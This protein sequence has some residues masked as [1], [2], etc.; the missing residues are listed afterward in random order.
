[1]KFIERAKKKLLDKIEEDLK[2]VE[3]KIYELNGDYSAKYEDVEDKRQKLEQAQN[4]KSKY[5]KRALNNKELKDLETIYNFITSVPKIEMILS[6]IKKMPPLNDYRNY[7]DTYSDKIIIQEE[8][9]KRRIFYEKLVALNELITSLDETETNLDSYDE[10]DRFKHY[11]EIINELKKQYN[12]F[13]TDREDD[14]LYDKNLISQI[15]LKIKYIQKKGLQEDKG[16]LYDPYLQPLEM[17]EEIAKYYSNIDYYLN[18]INSFENK[19]NY[20]MQLYEQ[21]PEYFDVK[22]LE[23]ILEENNRLQAILKSKQRHVANKKTEFQ[24]TRQKTKEVKK[25]LIA[26]EQRKKELTK[27]KARIEKAKSIKELGY[28][29]KKIAATKLSI[30][31]KDYIIIPIPSNVSNIVDLFNKET[32]LEVRIDDKCFRTFYLNDVAFGNLNSI[33]P[34]DNT[35]GAILIPVYELTKNHIDSIKNGKIGLSSSVLKIQ[36]IKIF[37]EKG[38][39]L[40]SLMPEAHVF[41]NKSIDEYV[42]DFL[43]EDYIEDSDEIKEYE[44]F[45]NIPNISDE[46]KMLKKAAVTKCLFENLKRPISYKDSIYVNGKKFFLNNQEVQTQLVNAEI[47][48]KK[49]LNITSKIKDYLSN[50]INNGFNIDILYRDLLMEYFHVNKKAKAEYLDEKDTTITIKEKNLSIKPMLPAKDE[51]IAKRYTRPNED[52]AYKIMKLANLV[53]RFAH[54]T[55][56]Q[57]LSDLLYDIKNDLIERVID[58]AK[59]NPQISLKKQFDENKMA[60]SVVMEIPGYNMIALHILNK[61]ESLSAKSHK[62]EENTKDVVQTSTILY[63]GVNRDLLFTMKK[64]NTNERIKLLLDLD[65]NTFYKL[66][67]RMGYNNKDINT[68]EEKVEFIKSIISD[69]KIDKMLKEYDEIEKE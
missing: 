44:V 58:L 13:L 33:Q 32:H 4:E 52:I 6:N 2:Q 28:K 46:E 65:S 31:T 9:G 39:K 24:A 64:M 66:I 38:Q 49:I 1:M 41:E 60:M 8:I 27:Q 16:L 17:W 7:P 37:I 48:E 35:I 25:Q 68:Y 54:M 40:A 34:L 55:E 56:K 10:K 47:D 51:D 69:E 43:G 20:F 42:K 14:R 62:L 5:Q 29:D 59:D 53:N 63:P 26:L 61:K 30:E 3:R 21:S 19:F 67:I 45:K 11:K 50:S 18:C 12:D 23:S 36:G 22:Y 15:L 57:D